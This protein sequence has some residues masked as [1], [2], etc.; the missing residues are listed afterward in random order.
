MKVEI[1]TIGDELLIGQVVDTNSAWMGQA[2]NNQGFQVAYRTAIGDL[3][4]DILDAFD[5]ALQRVPVV[6]VTGGIGPTKDDITKKT[7]CKYFNTDLCYSEE[8]NRNMEELFLT[9][10]RKMNELTRTQAYVPRGCTVI[11]NRAGTAPCTWFERDGRVL[12]SMPGVPSEMKW[13]MTNEVIPRLAKTFRR[14]VFIRHQTFWVSG[15]TESLLAITLED[16]ESSLP[17]TLK[18]A[19][20]PQAG[21]IRLR[22]SAYCPSEAEAE[23]QIETA[24]EK[25]HVLLNSHIMVEED[26]P[27]E[28]QIGELLKSK[29]LTI[30]TAESCTGGAI[31]SLLTSVPGSSDYFKGAIVSY[32]NEVKE[33]VLGVLTVDLEREGA[34]SRP[35][36]EQMARG[37]QRVL[38]CDCTVATSGIA[39]PGGGTPDKPVGTV[40][41]AVAYKD[42]VVSE[43]YKFGV[44]RDLNIQRTTNVGLLM[45]YSL[46]QKG[47]IYKEVP[48][49]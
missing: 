11:Q 9:N 21:I 44:V 39:G 41:I 16:F 20:L 30:G 29:G 7:L 28:V 13:L 46:V 49:P 4:Q 36:V 18:L 15:Y 35:V 19:Y 17:E 43:R 2:L 45:L 10:G 12:V 1:I 24:K 31:A 40:W 3:E 47:E 38:G 22:L 26:K 48:T 6:L 14:D 32:A 34:V 33:N 8:A 42:R 5:R 37:A 25:L 23:R 27:I